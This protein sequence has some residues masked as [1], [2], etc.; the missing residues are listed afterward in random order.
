VYQTQL[1]HGKKHILHARHSLFVF[2]NTPKM[3][4]VLLGKRS[5]P[6]MYL[7][8]CIE[9]FNILKQKEINHICSAFAAM[10]ADVD[11]ML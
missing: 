2:T 5:C 7:E 1:A 6:L 9:H 10:L 3:A 4:I 8:N 11:N